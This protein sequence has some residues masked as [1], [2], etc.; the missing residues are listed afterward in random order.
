MELELASTLGTCFLALY[1]GCSF[2]NLWCF[3]L[4]F[5]VKSLLLWM[6]VNVANKGI[7]A[8]DDIRKHK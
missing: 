8:R 3:K 2:V 4:T 5:V 1:Y 7:A 6:L